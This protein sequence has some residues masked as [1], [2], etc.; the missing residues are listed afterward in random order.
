MAALAALKLL[1]DDKKEV[2]LFALLENK[3][4]SVVL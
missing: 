3:I 2:E 1:V 4:V